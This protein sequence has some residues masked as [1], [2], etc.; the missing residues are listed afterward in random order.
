[1]RR[2]VAG[3]FTAN[4]G[5]AL[6]IA[7]LH[8]TGIA[9]QPEM[10]LTDDLATGRLEPVLPG[11]SYKPTP[12]YLIYAQ[13]RRPTAKLRSAIDFILAGFGPDR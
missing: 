5:G 9:M 13:D 4:H 7:A 11:W 6:R 12:M 10:L 3:R 8:G 2:A 1:M